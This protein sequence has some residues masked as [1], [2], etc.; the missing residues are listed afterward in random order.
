MCSSDLKGIAVSGAKRSPSAPEFATFIEA[1]LEGY[2]VY[3]WNGLYGPRGLPRDIVERLNAEVLKALALPEVKERFFQLGAE[4]APGR[5]EELG[6]YVRAE[7]ERW[8]RIVRER[9]IRI[10]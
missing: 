8:A 5:P 4:A 10:E 9:G 1:G 6:A 3:D 2:E 7:M